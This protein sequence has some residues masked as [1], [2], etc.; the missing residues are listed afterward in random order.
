MPF[1]QKYPKESKL[2]PLCSVCGAKILPEAIFCFECGVPDLPI[3]EPEETGISLEQAAIRIGVLVFLFVCLILVKYDVSIDELFFSS[4]T[5]LE[6]GS[7]TFRDNNQGD[8]LELIH[9]VIPSLA[10][11]RSKPSRDG[12]VVAVVEEGMNLIIVNK[13]SDWTKVRV[14]EK[15]GWIASRLIKSEIQNIK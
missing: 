10:K 1:S 7:L 6:S 5:V 15:T 13:K 9:T 12:Q 3:N 2:T 14:F 4:D 8:G 11:V